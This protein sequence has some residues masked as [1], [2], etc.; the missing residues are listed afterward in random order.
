MPQKLAFL[1]RN[2]LETRFS[3]FKNKFKQ[4]WEECKKNFERKI[5]SDIFDAAKTKTFFEYKEFLSPFDLISKQ[6]DLTD[7]FSNN[8]DFKKIDCC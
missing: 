7:T 2:N 3:S 1:D 4:F 5:N 6:N 8:T